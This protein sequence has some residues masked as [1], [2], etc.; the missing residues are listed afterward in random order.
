MGLK[1]KVCG[2]REE[3]NV[4][5]LGALQPDYMGFIFY[6]KSPRNVIGSVP[7]NI[8]K[9]TKKVGVFVNEPYTFVKQKVQQESLHYVQLHGEE[10]PAYCKILQAE[11]IPVIKAF[12]IDADFDFDQL[13]AYEEKVEYF[14][15]DAKG[16]ARGGNGISFDWTLLEQYQGHTPFLLAGGIHEEML[17]SIK[18]IQHQKFIGVD[19]NSKFEISPG[20]KDI[21]KLKQ[22]IND[23]RS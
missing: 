18:N 5:A 15:F 17:A 22:F 23:L 12:A 4:G 21:H 6:A 13:Y 19:L 3:E 8:S 7:K 20:L 11:G 2:M 1:I 9:A 14:L 16:V 10:T